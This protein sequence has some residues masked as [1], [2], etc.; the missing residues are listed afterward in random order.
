MSAPPTRVAVQPGG[1]RGPHRMDNPGCGPKGQE[2]GAGSAPCGA[3][4][5]SAHPA[6]ALSFPRPESGRPA[7]DYESGVCRGREV[8]ASDDA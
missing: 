4:R 2:S 1:N 6:S 7:H 3:R 8:M 5:V